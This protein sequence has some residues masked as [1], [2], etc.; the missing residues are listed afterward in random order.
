M[1]CS[2]PGE[3]PDSVFTPLMR[4]PDCVSHSRDRYAE[5]WR[6]ARE[7]AVN[8]LKRRIEFLNLSH[9]LCS[10]AAAINQAICVS[11]LSTG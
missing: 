9:S 3:T 5:G 2:H 1:L 7:G 11:P 4:V 8:L 6:L 10:E